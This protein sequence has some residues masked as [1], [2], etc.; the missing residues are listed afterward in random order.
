LPDELG[1]TEEKIVM[2]YF[3]ICPG[4]F[5]VRPKKIS[6]FKTTSVVEF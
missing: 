3:K 1:R 4:I 2:A 5:M 6:G